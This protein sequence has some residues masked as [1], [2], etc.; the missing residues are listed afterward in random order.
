MDDS[1]ETEEMLQRVAHGDMREWGALLERHRKRLRRM[2]A[3]R[4]DRRLHGRLDASDV[5]QEAYLEATARLPEYLHEP[6]MP[7][8]LW[9][10]FLT[11]Q[12]VM[13]LH[14]RHLGVQARDAGREVALC[15]GCLPEATS[16]ALAAHLLGHDTRP[17][18]A[19]IRAER[20]VRLQEALNNMD[21]LDREVLALRHFEQLNNAETARV[22]GLQPSAAS[23][24]YVRALTR[25]K[26]I[27][28]R[29]PGG[30]GGM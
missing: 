1:Q 22:L 15:R 27:L 8:F 16:A 12:K 6:A 5:I 7:F 9:L 3:L 20:K 24:R 4:L 21:P 19:A 23:K 30:A 29:L 13:E 26:D 14:R 2:V 18:E 25:L 10:R 28:T 11:G 17:S